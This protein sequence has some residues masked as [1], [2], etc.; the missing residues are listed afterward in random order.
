MLKTNLMSS[1]A[2][3]ATTILFCALLAACGGGGASSASSDGASATPAPSSV[4]GNT[5]EAAAALAISA[6]SQ[7]TT[8]GGRSVTLQASGFSFSDVPQ[9]S[10]RPDD[11]G[12]FDRTS[13]AAVRYIPPPPGAD[14]AGTVVY[15]TVMAG[16]ASATVPI[17]I[18]QNVGSAT[19]APAPINPTPSTPANPA[20]QSMFSVTA[21]NDRAVA[22]GD[23]VTVTASKPSAADTVVWSLEAGS[24]GSLDRTSGDTVQYIPPAAGSVISSVAVIVNASIGNVTKKTTIFLEGTQ[25]LSLFAGNDFGPGAVNAA[26]KSARFQDPYGIARDARGNLYVT[27]GGTSIRKITPEGS[28][29]T[30]AGTA[31]ASGSA[32]GTGASARFSA[33]TDIAIDAAGNLYVTDST[34]HTIRKIT[35]TGIV[36]TLAGTPGVK[37][38]TNGTGNAARFNRPSG[39]TV[40]ATGNLYV[41]D[42]DNM[43]IRKITSTGAVTT[44]AQ[45]DST[46]SNDSR[47]LAGPRGI[48]IDSAG[49]LYVVDQASRVNFCCSDPAYYYSSA[50]RKITPQGVVTT[51][52]GP[53]GTIRQ[54]AAGLFGS[55]DGSG[56]DARFLYPAG[57]TV[58]ASGNLYVTDS[59]NFTIRKITPAGVVSTLAGTAL[60]KGSVDGNG[61]SAR[62][63]GSR[64][65]TVDSEGN[66][67]LAESYNKTIRKLVAN[68]DV[69]TLAG[70]APSAGSRNG[71]G[72]SALFDGLKG[73]V[74][75]ALGNLYVADKWNHTVRKI[76][77]SGEVSTFAGT[78]GKQ[79]PSAD[80][81]E[82]PETIAI[83]GTGNLY[84]GSV[85]GIKKIS[86]AGV[87]SVVT[88][89]A[90]YANYAL[91]SDADGNLYTTNATD[92][93]KISP[94]G[95]VSTLARLR[96]GARALTVDKIGNVYAYADGLFKKITREGVVTTLAAAPAVSPNSSLR[97]SSLTT[98]QQGNLYIAY[99]NRGQTL[100]QKITPDGVVSTIFEYTGDGTS[101]G[102]HLYM[103]AGITMSGLKT[104]AITVENGV[105]LL[106]LP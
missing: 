47:L 6:E 54:G 64:D 5:P 27:D 67:Y 36:T 11:L 58:D 90:S 56:T 53:H 60:S 10:L 70:T 12:S 40:D 30:L 105:F 73:I 85:Y 43:M 32:D 71:I 44:F 46:T 99:S 66:L 51:L 86:P 16:K 33:I 49:N 28:V 31:S 21:Q 98:D 7:H 13:G 52:A 35:P 22:G 88:N 78:P 14:M 24:P 9:W 59:G 97:V 62:F 55:Q 79:G 19:D 91:T 50:V 106:G 34:S 42:T 100:I 77:P 68:G 92:V 94:A 103:P 18:I 95:A 61:S 104:M 93:L 69:I 101:S 1:I 38:R 74:S 29:T 23:R 25:G 3:R 80:L 72:A 17:T 20:Q 4:A 76:T 15:V 37:G 87:I 57:I 48:A 65:I 75:D 82:S 41:S 83:D 45:D 26:G 102:N 39:I 63:F 89:D 96:N 81:L 2:H 8:A 84:A